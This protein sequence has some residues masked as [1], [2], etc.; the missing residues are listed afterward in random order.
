MK[1]GDLVW[2]LERGKS[3]ALALVWLPGIVEYVDVLN[4]MVVRG[5]AEGER[6]R[7]AIPLTAGWW[8]H[9]HPQV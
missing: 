7:W 5:V 9:R 2:I 1:S 8:R 3:R 6:F 4:K